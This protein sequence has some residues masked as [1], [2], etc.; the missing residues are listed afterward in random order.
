MTVDSETNGIGLM[1]V[2]PFSLL[3]VRILE[4]A[5]CSEVLWPLMPPFT[6]GREARG[7]RT[8]ALETDPAA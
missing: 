4:Y 8:L 5:T 3:S 1:M 7:L 2:A 6:G